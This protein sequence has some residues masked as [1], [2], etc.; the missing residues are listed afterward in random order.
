MCLDSFSDLAHNKNSK[1]NV[2][3]ITDSVKQLL[4]KPGLFIFWFYRTELFFVVRFTLNTSC[5]NIEANP[6]NH[7]HD[8][9]LLV[10]EC[11]AVLQCPITFRR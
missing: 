7:T 5:Q 10:C 2:E 8:F 3:S 6:E 1:K 9:D 11:R 4:K